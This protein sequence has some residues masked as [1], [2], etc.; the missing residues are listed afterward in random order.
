[1]NAGADAHRKPSTL[2]RKLIPVGLSLL[3]NAVL[4]GLL[5]GSFS[6][7]AAKKEVLFAVELQ[8]L[9]PAEA[10]PRPLPELEVKPAP[11]T[12]IRTER[13][14]PNPPVQDRSA[15][16]PGTRPGQAR[17]TPPVYTTP[18][19]NTTVTGSQPRV[20]SAH[21]DTPGLA[22]EAGGTP[23][24]GPGAPSGIGEDGGIVG[25][26]RDGS[27]APAGQGPGEGQSAGPS[28]G[29]ENGGPAGSS[30]PASK[31][32]TRG[33]QIVN[34]PR[35]SYPLDARDE[36]VEG[37]VVLLASID[38]DGHVSKVRVERSSGDRRLD[39][40]AADAVEQ[41]TYNP[42]LRDGVP[43]TSTVRVRVQFRLE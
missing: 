32:E 17:P 23:A 18:K 7:S 5:A 30:Q 24:E 35:P 19:A 40:A 41:W 4:L 1:M 26:G 36:G 28:D 6:T 16:K 9:S 42:A 43:V 12:S 39:S 38:T 34:Q 27:G 11:K 29:H 3:V 21:V 2:G 20:R 31:G 10:S 8:L 25:D 15:R 22:A 33:P 13:P 14:R 37:T